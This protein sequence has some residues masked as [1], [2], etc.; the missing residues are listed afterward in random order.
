MKNTSYLQ[1]CSVVF[2]SLITA[3]CFSIIFSRYLG[4]GLPV[5]DDSH[6]AISRFISYHNAHVEGIILPRWSSVEQSGFGVPSFVFFY[7]LPHMLGSL[8]MFA[9]LN[10]QDAYKA[11][12]LFVVLAS[13]ACFF[14]WIRR[15]V[16]FHAAVVSSVIFGLC[17]SHVFNI[18]VRGPIGEILATPLVPLLLLGVDRIVEQTTIKRVLGEG[19]LIGL[20]I[21]THVISTI[22]ALPVVFGY[23]IVRLKTRSHSIAMLSSLIVGMGI[24]AFFWIPGLL[25][26]RFVLADMRMMEALPNYLIPLQLIQHIIMVPWFMSAENMHTIK[27]I[28]GIIMVVLVTGLGMAFWKRKHRAMTGYW[29]TV[30]ACSVFLMSSLSLLLW[31]TLPLLHLVH[32]PWRFMFIISFASAAVVAFVFDHIKSSA[33][34]YVIGCLS[35]ISFMSS[36]KVYGYVVTPYEYFETRQ[37]ITFSF[38]EALPVW[39]NTAMDKPASFPVDISSGNGAITGFVKTTHTHSFDIHAETPV[40]IVDNTQ[41]FPGWHVFVD[42][43]EVPMDFQDAQNYGL[44]VYDVPAGIHAVSV[45]FTDTPVRKAGVAITIISIAGVCML[46]YKRRYAKTWFVP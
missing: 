46:V 29:L 44:L 24:S 45:K 16:S 39:R 18:L 21:L 34:I 14:L 9:G 26:K 3:L 20:L 41:Y 13:P 28:D 5:L 12:V 7:P 37:E 36:M 40:R 8:L 2:F 43:H 31:Q 1:T 15:H 17:P 23:A 10:A 11:L 4:E 19:M 38:G 30:I 27:T 32:I 6:I 25:E 35:I 33:M 22:M 42:N